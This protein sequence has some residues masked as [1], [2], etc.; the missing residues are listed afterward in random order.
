[1]AIEDFDLVDNLMIDGGVTYPI[2]QSHVLNEDE[3]YRSLVSFEEC[4]LQ[5]HRH[6]YPLAKAI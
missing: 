2:I 4:L 5:R 6:Y 1:M 3:K